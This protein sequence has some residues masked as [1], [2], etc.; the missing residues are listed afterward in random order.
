MCNIISHL[1][2]HHLLRHEALQSFNM[3]TSIQGYTYVYHCYRI[4]EIKTPYC[5]ALQVVD[6]NTI[7]IM[8]R[9]KH[10]PN[11]YSLLWNSNDNELWYDQSSAICLAKL[12]ICLAN[13]GLVRQMYYALSMVKILSVQ[14]KSMSGQFSTPC[15]KQYKFVRSNLV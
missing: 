14:K 11:N 10:Y 7:L 5:P 1:N 6:N 3:N 12:S 4:P 8:V 13:L 9:S 15:Y 2:T